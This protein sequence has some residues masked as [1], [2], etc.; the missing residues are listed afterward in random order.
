M[1]E[2]LNIIQARNRAPAAPAW[3]KC[4]RL[5]LYR[6]PRGPGKI[7]GI[8]LVW[9]NACAPRFVLGSVRLGGP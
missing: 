7:Y 6:N 3:E 9:Y 1:S 8:N 5:T 4:G 2:H